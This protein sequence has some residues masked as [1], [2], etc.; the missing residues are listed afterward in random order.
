MEVSTLSHHWRTTCL[1]MACVSQGYVYSKV[2]IATYFRQTKSLFKQNRKGNIIKILPSCL[3]LYIETRVQ[4]FNTMMQSPSALSLPLQYMYS[5]VCDKV[6]ERGM[7][8]QHYVGGVKYI[9]LCVLRCLYRPV[10]VTN[11]APL[12]LKCLSPSCS[13]PGGPASGVSVPV[14]ALVSVP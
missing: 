8:G 13:A 1:C 9:P 5:C 11:D 10:Y 2:L 6:I 12:L 3:V 4:T 7:H 14:P